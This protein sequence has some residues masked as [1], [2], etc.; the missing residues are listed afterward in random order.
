MRNNA[1]E[2]YGVMPSDYVVNRCR[3]ISKFAVGNCCYRLSENKEIRR[4][5]LFFF[6]VGFCRY[7]AERYLSSE[8]LKLLEK[9]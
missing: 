8:N 2:I 6:A 3:K 1:V 5:K 7:I 9:G 4:R